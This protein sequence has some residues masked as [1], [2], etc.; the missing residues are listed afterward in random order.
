MPNATIS[1][2]RITDEGISPTPTNVVCPGRQY[3]LRVWN[4][5]D[6]TTSGGESSVYFLAPTSISVR[7]SY[8]GVATNDPR[9]V[10][11]AIVLSGPILIGTSIPILIAGINTNLNLVPSPDFAQVGYNDAFTNGQQISDCTQCG[12]PGGVCDLNTKVC[13]LTRKPRCA[14]NCATCPTAWYKDWATWLTFALILIFLFLVWAVVRA[15]PAQKP[16]KVD[17]V[18]QVKEAPFLAS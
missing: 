1:F 4:E 7:G 3:A 15:L 16:I 10:A 13:Q 5:I 11:R 12:C 18:P 9:R 8:V 2:Y 17:L 14:C 6:G